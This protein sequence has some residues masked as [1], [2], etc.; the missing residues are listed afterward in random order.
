MV[1]LLFEDD[2]VQL[3]LIGSDTL[4]PVDLLLQQLYL[5]IEI[6]H[7][8][9]PLVNKC[10]ITPTLASSN[11]APC[12]EQGHLQLDQAAQSP[13]QPDL[14]CLQGWGIYHLSGQPVP[15]FHHHHCKNV[16]LISSLNLT[17][18][19]L[20]PLPFVLLLQAL[21]KSLSPSFLQAEQCPLSQ[22]FL[23][24]EVFQPSHHFCGPPLDL[25][26]QVHVFPALRA[27]ELDE[28]LQGGS[29]QS[30]AEGQNHLLHPTGHTFV[31][32]A[33]DTVGFL[34]CKCT[35]LAQVQLFIHQYP[36]VLLHR[37]A[38]NPFIL[39]HVL[40]LG[41]T[42]TQVQD[43]ALGLVEPHEVHTGPLLQLVQVPLDDIPSFWCVNCTTQ[44]GVICKLAEGALDLAVNVIDE[45]TDQHWSQYG[46]LR[47]TTCHQSPSSH[48]LPSGCDHPTNFSSTEHPSTREVWKKRLSVKTEAKRLLSTSAFSWSVVTSLPVVFIRAGTLSLTFLF[49]LTSSCTLAFLTPS[50]HNRAASLYSSQVTYPCFH[51]LCSSLLPFSLTSRSRLIHA[52]LLPSFPDF[53]HLGIESSC[54][55]W[56]ASLK[57]C[58]LSSAPLSLG[59]VS[60]GILLNNC[61]KCWNFAFLKFSVLTLLFT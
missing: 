9:T 60:Q 54:T 7:Q 15:V 58:Q 17:S 1:Q 12:N 41:A 18:F 20:K 23:I 26:Q 43:L 49:W 57:I 56:K 24:E 47:D 61:L 39:Q 33:Q 46:P 37:A 34:G 42:P 31:D 4:Q 6:L 48:R 50:L 16:F 38:L 30:G 19:S 21:P 59:A 14:E 11:Q 5:A 40:I 36:K 25:L 35:L 8:Q 45:N 29:H 3:L 13:I 53:L 22:P 44:L 10:T 55:L 2:S 52:S 28:V 51:C 27:P 32:A